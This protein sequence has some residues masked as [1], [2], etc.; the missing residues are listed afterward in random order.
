MEAPKYCD[1]PRSHSRQIQVLALAGLV[2]CLFVCSFVYLFIYLFI[3]GGRE[4]DREGEKYQCVVALCTPPTWDLACNLGT[5]P[6][7]E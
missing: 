4:E 7:W 5:C 6:D 2:S 1:S 3:E